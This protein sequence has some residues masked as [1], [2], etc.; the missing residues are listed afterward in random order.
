MRAFSREHEPGLTAQVGRGRGSQRW[1]RCG[2]C[3]RQAFARGPDLCAEPWQSQ[4][5]NRAWEVM[6]TPEA[7]ITFGQGSEVDR[8]FRHQK[9]ALSDGAVGPPTGPSALARPVPDLHAPGAR[10]GRPPLGNGPD[11]SVHL[12][13]CRCSPCCLGGLFTG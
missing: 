1:R 13:L 5:Q 10:S 4:P 3:W 6:C 2:P 9:K 8:N 7:S 11:V 12:C